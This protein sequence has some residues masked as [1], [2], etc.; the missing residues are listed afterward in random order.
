MNNSWILQLIHNQTY[1]QQDI[2]FMVLDLGYLIFHLRNFRKF[3]DVSGSFGKFGKFPD[4][5]DGDIVPK[6]S[7]QDLKVFICCSNVI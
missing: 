4:T 5:L 6:V 7:T 2:V 1:K 3:R